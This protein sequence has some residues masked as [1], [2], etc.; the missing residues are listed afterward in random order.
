M[1][2]VDDADS[3]EFFHSETRKAAKDH[4]CYECNRVIAKGEQHE[5]AG[6]RIDG[7][8]YKSRTCVHCVEAK[9]W[10][11]VV[12]RGYLFGAVEEDLLDHVVGDESELRSRPLT[13]L[14]RWMQKDWHK[15]TGELRPVEDVSA[16]TDEAIA[17]Y[18]VMFDKAV[19]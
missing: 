14:V 11:V 19:A 2:M 12:C 6:G 1:C 8:F 5:Y 4:K 9:R 3:W 18:R 7:H 17:A 16:I 13:R 15:P 10:L